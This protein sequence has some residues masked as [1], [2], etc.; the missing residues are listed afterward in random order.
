MSRRWMDRAVTF[1]VAAFTIT[2]AAFSQTVPNL[3]NGVQRVTSVEGIAEYAL[4]NGSH[5]LLFRAWER[6]PFPSRG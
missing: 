3:T 2:F 4:P 6:P 5:V 1:L